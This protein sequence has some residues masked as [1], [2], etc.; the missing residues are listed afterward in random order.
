MS[1]WCNWQPRQV[2]GLVPSGVGVR[3][4]PRSLELIIMDPKCNHP[5]TVLVDI[6]SGIG[7]YACTRIGCNVQKSRKMDED[8]TDIYKYQ[9]HQNIDR[10]EICDWERIST[11][12]GHE[13]YRCNR[14]AK[15]SV[16]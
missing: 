7:I 12:K 4:P 11:M 8:I 15:L 5:E 2:E 1:E 10:C 9:C 13:F 16:H 6:K 14:C 3:I